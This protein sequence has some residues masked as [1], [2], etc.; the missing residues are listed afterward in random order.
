MCVSV[1]TYIYM[2]KYATMNTNNFFLS[3]VLCILNIFLEQT[4]GLTL[5]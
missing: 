5:L 2:H 4:D 1:Y 3:R